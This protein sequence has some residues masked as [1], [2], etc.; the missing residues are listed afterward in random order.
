MA[1]FCIS[2]KRLFF[3]KY[4]GTNLIIA[5]LFTLIYDA[6][7]LFITVVCNIAHSYH[8]VFSSNQNMC[9]SDHI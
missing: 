9:F 7:F 2:G 6:Y 1:V 5:Y 4:N 8:C 3:S